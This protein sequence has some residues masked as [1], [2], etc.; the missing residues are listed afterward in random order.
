MTATTIGIVSFLLITL[1]VA[2]LIM[3]ALGLV[4]WMLRPAH[5]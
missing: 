3:A 5:Y 4:A 2:G 1:L